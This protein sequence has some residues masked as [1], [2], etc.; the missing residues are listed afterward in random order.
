M[1]KLI[2]SF[3]AVCLLGVSNLAFS[4]ENLCPGLVIEIVEDM[5]IT[6]NDLNKENA[7]KAVNSIKEI[8]E[9]N[10]RGLNQYETSLRRLNSEKILKGYFL[11]IDAEREKKGDDLVKGKIKEYCI[12][13]QKEAFW[14]E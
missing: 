1:N 7:L 11:K 8:I 4:S 2:K 6:P 13:L 12:F 14:Y 10:H 5:R 9:G 3:L